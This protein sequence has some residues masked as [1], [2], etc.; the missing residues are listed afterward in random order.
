MGST[1]AISEGEISNDGNDRIINVIRPFHANNA[2]ASSF[3]Y[4]D[5]YFFLFLSLT[6][7]ML[8][9]V[10]SYFVSTFNVA[11][12]LHVECEQHP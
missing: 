3:C 12:S 6:F 5:C 8:Y 11:V 2:Y 1:D 9:H 7:S 10:F 4:M